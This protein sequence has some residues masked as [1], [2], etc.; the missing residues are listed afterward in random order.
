MDVIGLAIHLDQLTA[1]P[2]TSSGGDLAEAVEHGCRDA[3]P[4][5]LGDE[6]QVIVEGVNTMIKLGE[7]SL[8]AMEP[9]I[10]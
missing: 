1:P 9:S 8:T 2:F 10:A 4:T 3:L 5:I 6:N 7:L